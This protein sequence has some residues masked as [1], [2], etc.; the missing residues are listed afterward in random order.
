MRKYLIIFKRAEIWLLLVTVAGLIAFSFQSDD[1]S[2]PYDET[3][4]EI[5]VLTGKGPVQSPSMLAVVDKPLLMVE[6]VTLL[7][8]EEGSIVELT[9]LGRSPDGE[10]LELNDSSLKAETDTGD[11]V[12]FFFEPFRESAMLRGEGESLA[13]VRLWLGSPAERL[14]LEVRGETFSA[15]LPQ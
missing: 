14:L 11:S 13:T 4:P 1:L 5:A 3:E 12:Q 10:D 9:L 7:Q 2:Q 8:T 6:E 15:E